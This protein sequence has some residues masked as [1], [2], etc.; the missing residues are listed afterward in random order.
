VQ[1]RSP[2]FIISPRRLPEPA[3][4]ELECGKGGVAAVTACVRP[5][6]S[7]ERGDRPVAA[8][9]PILGPP[10]RGPRSLVSF[11]NRAN[12]RAVVLSRRV[13]CRRG[14]KPAS[15]RS[16]LVAALQSSR[17]AALTRA[18]WQGGKAEAVGEGSWRSLRELV[19]AVLAELRPA[20]DRKGLR[21]KGYNA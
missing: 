18:L 10:P 1:D 16:I 11:P 4:L 15:P 12:G 7:V 6:R 13:G 19:G 8:L 14:P 9:R 17:R 3:R 5:G 21:E 20:L 2:R